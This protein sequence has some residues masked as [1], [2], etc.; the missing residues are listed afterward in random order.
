MVSFINK[1][2]GGL[3]AKYYWRQFFF[4]VIVSVIN[5]MIMQGKVSTHVM[6]TV[7][8]YIYIAINILLYPYSRF[9]YESIVG[10]ILGRNIFYMNSIVF[11][12]AKCIT[13]YICWALSIVIA[14][15]GIIYLYIYHSRRL[16]NS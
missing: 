12:I 1:T 2:F 10:F 8:F 16:G 13:I 6:Q 7:Y 9:V 4:G 15:L 14:P 5:L 3:S 11:L